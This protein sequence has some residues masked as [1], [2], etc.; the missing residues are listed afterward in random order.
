M[1]I[2]FFY[3]PIS[4]TVPSRTIS[5]IEIYNI[6]TKDAQLKLTTDLYRAI[7]LNTE[8]SDYKR[9]NF[10]YVTFSGVFKS[11]KR[12][13][14]IEYSNLIAIDIDSINK[15]EL[16][17]L[18]E[19]AVKCEYVVFAYETPSHGYKMIIK[20]SGMDA[21][22][23]TYISFAEYLVS[24]IGIEARKVDNSCV[25]ICRANFLCHDSDA[26]INSK[27]ISGNYDEIPPY[28]AA[29]ADSKIDNPKVLKSEGV[30]SSNIGLTG[31]KLD[32]MNKNSETNFRILVGI[33]E[34]KEGTYKSP[35]QTWIQRLASMCNKFGIELNSTMEYS[36]KY[37]SN[38][39]ES[40]RSEKPIDVQHY[41]VNT[42]NDTY[43]RYEDQF[44]TWNEDVQNIETPM[45]PDDVFERLPNILRSIM[46]LYA[47]DRRE[48][49]MMLLS[50]ITIISSC[51]PEYYG[52]Y[53]NRIVSP[54]LFLFISAPPSSGKGAVSVVKNIGRAIQRDLDSKYYSLLKEYEQAMEDYKNN[55]ERTS[56]PIKPQ[57]QLFFI[58]SNSSSTKLIEVMS[59]NV[60]FGALMET[61]ADT[62][63]QALK[64]DWGSFSDTLRKAFHN[65]SIELQRVAGG[66][67]INIEKSYLSVLLTGTPNQIISLINNVENGLLSRF[68]FYSFVEEPVWKDAFEMKDNLPE[69]AYNSLSVTIEHYM[70]EVQKIAQAVKDTNEYGLKFILTPQQ[71]DKFNSYFK[72][73]EQLLYHIYGNDISASVR[74]HGLSAFRMAMLFSILRQM[75]TSNVEVLL[76]CSDDDFDISLSIIDVLLQHTIKVY[77]DIKAQQHPVK[78]S[79]KQLEMDMYYDKLPTEFNFQNALTVAKAMGM[80]PKTAEYRLKKYIKM[81]LLSHTHNSYKKA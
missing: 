50:T 19:F 39:E 31:Y 29:I 56:P 67:Y 35:R 46:K 68:I 26:F 62:L 38:H 69:L 47:N 73:Q 15:S 5:I 32:H 25:D 75:D 18:K 11:R 78:K 49:D 13:E 6:V 66:L 57:R 40:I 4:N 60:K 45:L 23:N 8:R 28:S 7:Q 70:N 16:L 54:N 53:H 71:Q 77:S 48:R 10:P 34:R 76:K 22:A 55:E 24:S 65:E 59:S 36:L 12:A 74:R 20:T 37:F 72:E 81:G 30:V 79:L 58:P 2:S 41:I 17:A 14:L 63:C 33:L 64:N 27:I 9:M 21:H 1:I 61:E 42:I 43:K 44:S 80:I 52:I 51:F 3:A